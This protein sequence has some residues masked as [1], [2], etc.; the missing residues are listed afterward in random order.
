MRALPICSHPPSGRSEGLREDCLLH[1]AATAAG[2][3]RE[4]LSRSLLTPFLY[5]SASEDGRVA[6]R[7]VADAHG[8]EEHEGRDDEHREARDAVHAM[9]FSAASTLFPFFGSWSA[10]CWAAPPAGPAVYRREQ[11]PPIQHIAAGRLLLGESWGVAQIAAPQL[12][13]VIITES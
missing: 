12:P 10:T 2:A 13:R 3:L 7:A 11:R 6:R 5:S 4:F 9:V 8:L 1:F